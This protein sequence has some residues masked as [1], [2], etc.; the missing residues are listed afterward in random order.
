MGYQLNWRR[1]RSTQR[2]AGDVSN[3]MLATMK[4]H[5]CC[6]SADC[7][8]P[9]PPAPPF[10]PTQG[11]CANPLEVGCDC[12]GLIK[13]FEAGAWG[14]GVA[15]APTHPG[16]RH[17]APGVQGAPLMQQQIASIPSSGSHRL[18]PH[19]PSNF[20]APTCQTTVKH[21]HRAGLC[22]PHVLQW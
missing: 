7:V 17:G 11:L 22:S 15:A 19:L 5:A 21:S 16:C 10:H 9:C 13:D 18:T 14:Q 12:L 2:R 4:V 1:G 3:Q 8:A 6:K 20:E